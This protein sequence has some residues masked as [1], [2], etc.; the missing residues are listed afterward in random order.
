MKKYNIF[1][2]EIDSFGDI[3]DTLTLLNRDNVLIFNNE[4]IV[5]VIEDDI[6]NEYFNKSKDLKKTVE[7]RYFI[8]NKDGVL[9]NE[10]VDLLADV[11]DKQGKHLG[12]ILRLVNIKAISEIDIFDKVMMLDNQSYDKAIIFYDKNIEN[13]I[14]NNIDNSTIKDSCAD[15][16]NSL[17]IQ[18]EQ[19]GYVLRM[20]GKAYSFSRLML[21]DLDGN[22]HTNIS[23]IGQ[24]TERAF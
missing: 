14:C 2:E 13:F 10:T 21:H 12:Y 6:S 5:F 18:G 15:V 9:V 20:K 16:D 23:N 1:K 8:F 4:L 3:L 24:F 7:M 17:N 19:G 11:R 22:T